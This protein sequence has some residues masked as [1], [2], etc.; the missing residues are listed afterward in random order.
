MIKQ[1]NSVIMYSTD[2]EAAKR[3]Y[4][5]NLGFE[6]LYHVP[7]AFL[8]MRHPQMGRLDFHP[9]TNA[10]NIGSGPL[11]NYAVTDIAKVKAWLEA[12]GV[13]VSDIQQ[14]GDSP[15]HAWFWDHEGNVVGLEED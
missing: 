4:Q 6:I 15:R 14:A 7:N 3:W 1:I 2:L 8:S 10:N 11:A 12:K 9:T 5:D 13:K